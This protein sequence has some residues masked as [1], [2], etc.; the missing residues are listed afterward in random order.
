VLVEPLDEQK[1][2]EKRHGQLS[3]SNSSLWVKK[4]VTDSFKHVQLPPTSLQ[5][6]V[7]SHFGLDYASN[8]HWHALKHSKH[9]LL[10]DSKVAITTLRR[11]ALE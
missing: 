1:A 7:L 4:R 8:M 3:F 11:C 9:T 6:W 10:H 5:H 2:T